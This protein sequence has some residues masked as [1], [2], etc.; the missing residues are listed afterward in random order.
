[1]TIAEVIEKR[2]ASAMNTPGKTLALRVDPVLGTTR[3]LAR[4]PVRRK[5]IPGRA[6][7]RA[8]VVEKNEKRRIAVIGLIL[9]HGSDPGPPGLP[10]N[11]RFGPPPGIVIPISRKSL[12][13]CR[14]NPKEFGA[15][16]KNGM[17]KSAPRLAAR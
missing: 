17:K 16:S 4:V 1:M 8:A 5:T 9:H 12:D 2:V 14:S 10:R 11:A 3:P 6:N 13:G 7:L 15:A